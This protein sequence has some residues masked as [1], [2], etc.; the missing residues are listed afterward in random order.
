M[1]S[2]ITAALLLSLALF[3]DSNREPRIAYFTHMRDIDISSPARQNYFDIDED[4]WTRAR[5]DLGD[6]RLY[7]QEKEVPYCLVEE[8]ASSSQ[9]EQA[10]KILQLGKVGEN[11]SFVLEVPP[12][13]EYNRV[14]L[15][16][17]TKNFVTTANIEGMDEIRG[18][19]GTRMGPYTLYDFT[20]E[21]L[22]SNSTLKLPDSRFRFLRITLN[23]EISPD[24]VKGA[25]I[26][27]SEEKKAGYTPIGVLL[28]VEQAGRETVINWISPINVPL[29]RLVFDVD[30]VNFLRNVRVQDDAGRYAGSGEISRVKMTRSGRTVESS[31]LAL[32]L[33]GARANAFRVTIANGDDPPLKLKTITPQ[34]IT[35]RVYFD[36]QGQSKVRLYYGDEKLSAPVYEYAR[37]NVLEPKP[38][39]A[40]L[41]RAAEN[42]A[43]TGR[44]DERPWTE[45]HPAVLW[46]AM[47]AVIAVLGAIALR[48]LR[49]P[50]AA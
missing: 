44:P 22:G 47:L 30:Q 5:A 9:T 28:T 27:F 34:F 3:A 6:L 13:A 17:A 49:K 1:K 43:F 50:P 46:A 8:R 45:R 2:S 39:A 26:S 42:T 23:R 37:L 15:Q 7:A 29:D 10:A 16:L 24:D 14:N 4:T 11:T 25:N 18:A 38:A 12:D 33:A 35:R 40:Q 41:G 36:P 32:D 20:R 31:N 48:G 19:R 21:G